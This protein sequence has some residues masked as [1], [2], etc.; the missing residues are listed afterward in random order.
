VG[1]RVENEVGVLIYY[2]LSEVVMVHPV[3]GAGLRDFLRLFEYC[4]T[5]FVVTKKVKNITRKYFYAI[6]IL[7]KCQ[8]FLLV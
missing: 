2:A 5:I 6:E 7:K 4:F 1:R 3:R 8:Y